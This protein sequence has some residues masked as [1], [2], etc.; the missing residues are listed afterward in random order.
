MPTGLKM[1]NVRNAIGL[2]ANPRDIL[3][4]TEIFLS[5]IFISVLLKFSSRK[6]VFDVIKPKPRFEPEDKE[7]YCLKLRSY[8]NFL[9]SRNLPCFNLTCM[10]RALV[11]YRFLNL[12][13]IDAT[14]CFG[15]RKKDWKKD[16]AL[17]HAWASVKGVPFPKKSDYAADFRQVCSFP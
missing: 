5:I 6:R 3:L 2:A 13:G 7:E 17:I 14:L 9:L 12:A 8:T 16:G 10:K 11:Y 4:F 15:V 1:R